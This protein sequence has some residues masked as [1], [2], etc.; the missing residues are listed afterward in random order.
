MKA[1]VLFADGFEDIQLF[2]PWYR[3]REDGV[4]LTLATPS[5]AAAVG[6]HGYTV[7]ADSPI[8]ELNPAEYDLLVIPGGLSAA[9]LRVRENAVAVARTFAED[10][11]R[12]VAI[13]HGVQLLISAG[14]IDGKTVTCPACIRD[15]VRNAGATFR[16]EA[17]VTDGALVTCRGSEDLPAL[18]RRLHLE[19][20]VRA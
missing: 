9:R 3:L 13:E 16:D 14:V 12:I 2:Y 6:Q 10:G 15:D 1:L 8:D 7:E 4:R 17:V 20:L 11:K 5:G 19:K 18:G